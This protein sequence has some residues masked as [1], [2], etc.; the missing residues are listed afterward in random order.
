VS[1]R[2]AR[3]L[4]YGADARE[5][6]AAGVDLV[7]RAVGPTFGPRGRV[8]VLDSRFGT[9]ELSPSYI[10]RKMDSPIL[11][12]DGHAVAQEI[13]V[14]DTFLNQ[15]VLLARD[16][17]RAIK[18]S[19]GDGSTTA[20]LLTQGLV[21]GGVKAIASGAEPRAVERG[22]E[23]AVDQ[24][25]ERLRAAATPISGPEQ[26][27]RV[28]SSA[29]GGD[30]ELADLVA[31]ALEQA[32]GGHIAFEP[33]RRHES[34]LEVSTDYAIDRGL[35][36]PQF[37]TDE[38]TQQAILEDAYVLIVDAKVTRGRDLAPA[39]E[40]A[41]AAKRPLLILAEEFDADA[42]ALLTVN[43][44]NHKVVGV[45]VESPGYGESRRETLGDIAAW[46]GATVVGGPDQRKLPDVKLE[47]LG[48]AGRIAVSRGLTRIADGRGGRDAVA[49]RVAS[50]ARMAAEA[51]N[52]HDRDELDDRR[53][54][55]G[56]QGVATV[57]IGGL[58]ETE[59]RGR[60]R[61]AQDALGAARS[62]LRHGVLPGG[63]ATLVRVAGELEAPAADTAAL[64]NDDAVGFA[65]VRDALTAPLRVLA[66]T[67]G[68]DAGHVVHTVRAAPAGHGY[69]FENGCVCDL[70]EAGIVD[71][72]GVICEALESAAYVAKRVIATEVLI[73]QPI[74]AGKYLGTAAEGGPANL[75]MP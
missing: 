30:S 28:A 5:A 69:D 27:S 37:V 39:L 61:A 55:L 9:P 14:A 51:D 12:D 32:K 18:L 40:L 59:V 72:A 17:G 64:H 41:A 19:T 1:S 34:S 46:T 53:A 10:D 4:R 45:P 7:A 3:K 71:S 60:T 48:E 47:D 52:V 67:A 63:A 20:I 21:Q 8:V 75:S 42:L 29:A 24:A 66:S 73:V 44:I 36:S 22:M 2:P 23:A 35:V 26:V 56:G 65:L 11:A 58:T 70:M 68:L 13:L 54:R 43:F 38:E 31:R 25:L 57:A 33:S 6:L 62:A 74:Y 15:G 50:L 49:I 16:A